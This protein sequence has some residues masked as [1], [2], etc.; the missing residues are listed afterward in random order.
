MKD[1]T[2]SVVGVLVLALALGLAF[3]WLYPLVDMSSE[4]AALFVFVAIVL[5]L[6]LARLWALRRKPP[7][8]GDVKASQ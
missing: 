6:L 3:R 2:L 1:L 7:A 8:P 4:L 5:R